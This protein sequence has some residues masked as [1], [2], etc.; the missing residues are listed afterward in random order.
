MSKQKEKGKYFEKQIANKFCKAL[1]LDENECTRSPNSGNG[2]FEFG[3]IFFTNPKVNPFAIECKFGYKW[4]LKSLFPKLNTQITSFL[5][6][7]EEAREKMESKMKIKCKMCCLLLSKPYWPV[8]LLTYDY[9]SDKISSIITRD[10]HG[11]KVYIYL[12][13]DILLGEVI[14]ENG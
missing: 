7:A 6:Q 14:C 13:D 9:I 4:D 12:L 3:D 11:V 10:D 8:Y 5:Y 2:E 1:N